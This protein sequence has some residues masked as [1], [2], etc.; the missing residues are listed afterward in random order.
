MWHPLMDLHLMCPIVQLKDNMKD[1]NN[2]EW[3]KTM[4]MALCLEQKLG[5]I[6]GLILIPKEDPDKEEE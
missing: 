6:D 3:A 4:R 5:F 2:D 1:N